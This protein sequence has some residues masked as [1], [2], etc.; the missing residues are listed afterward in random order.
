MGTKG[1]PFGYLEFSRAIGR[2]PCPHARFAGGAGWPAGA[3]ASAGSGSGPG[4]GLVR[5]P[6]PV[7]FNAIPGLTGVGYAE[8]TRS[9]IRIRTAPR[10]GY[11]PTAADSWAVAAV[12]TNSC[13]G[14]DRTVATARLDSDQ[15]T[16][17]GAL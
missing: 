5:V 12:E 10:N 8:H 11:Q 13:N 2:K 6:Y 16:P 7:R 4:L 17:P 15:N 3:G 9:A 14:Q 1:V